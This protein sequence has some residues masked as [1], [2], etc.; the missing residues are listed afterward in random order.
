M[1][2]SSVPNRFAS[3]AGVALDASLTAGLAGYDRARF[4]VQFRRLTSQT[5]RAET[6]A[7]ARLVLAEIEQAM[8]RER[9]RGGHWSYDLNRHIALLVAHRAERARLTRILAGVRD[10]AAGAAQG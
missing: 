2:P 7:A 4:L 5:I 8:R 3:H 1:V 9:A 10:G 6:P